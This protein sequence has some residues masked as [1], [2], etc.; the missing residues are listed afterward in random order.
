MSRFLLVVILFVS[1]Q[2]Y[3]QKR[4]SQINYYSVDNETNKEKLI[5][6]LGFV[7]T[8]EKLTKINAKG[9]NGNNPYHNNIEFKY[10]GDEIKAYSGD[11]ETMF[12]CVSENGRPVRVYYGYYG[13]ELNLEYDAD[14]N[15]T[16]L[17]IDS[18]LIDH[19]VFWKYD[20]DQNRIVTAYRA[21]TKK[22]KKP[23]KKDLEEYP[24]TYVYDNG[25][26]S[27]IE[28]GETKLSCEYED[29][30]VTIT[31]GRYTKVFKYDENNILKEVVYKKGDSS[32]KKAVFTY[33]DGKGNEDLYLGYKDDDLFAYILKPKYST[34]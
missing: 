25:K 5:K 9:Y 26:L 2:C 7:Y 28:T 3:P 11:G 32:I 21:G 14:G 6:T 29:D 30:M 20:Y 13:R 1:F 8:G 18:R 10:N 31:H 17:I 12:E 16:S 22:K 15:V 23:K 4:V 33:G 34:K 19:M 24:M 27:K